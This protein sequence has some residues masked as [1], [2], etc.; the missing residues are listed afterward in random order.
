MELCWPDRAKEINWTKKPKFL[1]KELVKI[2]REGNL[3]NRV[4]DKLIE[5]ELV[6][7][8]R[9][10]IILHLEIQST[11]QEEFTERMFT[12][13]YRLRDFYRQPIAS[14]ALLL[15]DDPNWRPNSYSESLWDSE[16]S[17]KF[18]II[19]LTDYNQRIA[20]LEQSTHPF[21]III[22]AQLAALNKQEV[23]LKLASK[24]G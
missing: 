24:K 8:D 20:E 9:C 1:D 18:P 2:A 3:G 10:C 14:V 4:V 19:K 16:I 22:L 12:Y 11:K 23:Q 6:S 7:G 21:A 15:D 17:I 5:V 13:R